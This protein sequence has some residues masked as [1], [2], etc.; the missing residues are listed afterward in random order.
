MEISRLYSL[1][2]AAYFCITSSLYLMYTANVERFKGCQEGQS[3]YV[4][5]MVHRYKVAN[6]KQQT[7]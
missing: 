2:K 7:N 5:V 4:D 6:C 1:F 3:V